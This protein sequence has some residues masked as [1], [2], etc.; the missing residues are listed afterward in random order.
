VFQDDVFWRAVDP[1]AL[2]A[3]PCAQGT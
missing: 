3:Q 2:N 1:E